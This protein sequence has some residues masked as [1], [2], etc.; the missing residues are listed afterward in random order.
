MT[1]GSVAGD[2]IVLVRP[3]SPEL[4]T[5]VTPAATAASSTFRT[6]SRSVSGKSP[7][8]RDSFMTLAPCCTA[9]STAWTMLEVVAPWALPMTFRAKTEAPGATPTILTQHPLSGKVTPRAGFTYW[10]RLYTSFPWATIELASPN[11]SAPSVMAL[12]PSPEKSRYWVIA[13]VPAWP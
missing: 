8:P 2:P 1:S 4:V 7:E 9:Y 10:A 5:T 6:T 11:A 3:A 13:G 12:V